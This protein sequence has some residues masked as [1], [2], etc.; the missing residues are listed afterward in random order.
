[1]SDDSGSSAHSQAS[2]SSLRAKL[3]MKKDNIQAGL[4]QVVE[5]NQHTREA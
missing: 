4:L 1:M 5:L 2:L 3:V